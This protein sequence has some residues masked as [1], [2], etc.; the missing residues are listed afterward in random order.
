M[1]YGSPRVAKQSVKK[2]RQGALLHEPA[3]EGGMPPIHLEYR[4]PILRASLRP[5]GRRKYGG[6]RRLRERI[7]LQIP[8]R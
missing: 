4:K 8:S 2:K 5:H 7:P 1:L 6:P 3:T